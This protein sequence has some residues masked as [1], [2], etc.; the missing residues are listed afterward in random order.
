MQ[1]ATGAT[2]GKVLIAKTIYGK[3]AA[4][5]YHPKKRAVRFSLLPE[6]VDAMGNFEFF[7][8]CKKGIEPSQIPLE[9]RREVIQWTYE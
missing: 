7:V 1:I 6:F 9:V 4:T 8:Y 3:L 2:Y 5:F